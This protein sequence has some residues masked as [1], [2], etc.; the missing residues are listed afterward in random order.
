MNLLRRAIQFTLAAACLAALA[1]FA[2]NSMNIRYATVL[3]ELN[4][5]QR[6]VVERQLTG[7]TAA[8][9]EFDVQQI[10]AQ[11]ESN[12]WIRHVSVAK[13][14]PS[15]LV[16]TVQPAKVVAHWNDDAF[17]TEG[18]DVLVT[19][20][21][22]FGDLPHLYG[23]PDSQLRVMQA[24]Q[25]L[26]R[27][28]EGAGHRIE[29]LRLSELGA[30]TFETEEGLLVLLGREDFKGRLDRF[31]KVSAWAAETGAVMGRA[32]TRYLSG[33]AIRNIN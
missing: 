9:G 20:F 2:M 27:S 1:A 15:T 23:P 17:I 26:S 16:V 19:K 11:L 7:V 12:K 22:Q 25:Q 4:G 33:V 14:W 10:K 21:L 24:Y 28:L 6:Q 30:W 32:D 31:L 5:A 29:V 18:A 8:A 13:R 3:G